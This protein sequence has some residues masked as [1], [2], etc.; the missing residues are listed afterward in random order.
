MRDRFLLYNKFD[1]SNDLY[2]NIYV[3]IGLLELMTKLLENIT[4]YDKR[5]SWSA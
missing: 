4:I 5:Y 2:G 3:F 1:T